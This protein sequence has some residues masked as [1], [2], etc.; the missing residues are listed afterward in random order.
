MDDGRQG[1]GGVEG[2]GQQV[3]VYS[4]GIVLA[5]LLFRVHEDEVADATR[6]DTKGP[7]MVQR[8]LAFASSGT[9]GG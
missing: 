5:Q 7:A 1:D 4:A 6:E 3:D 2:Y 8:V 9:G